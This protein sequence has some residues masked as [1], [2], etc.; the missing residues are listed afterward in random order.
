MGRTVTKGADGFFR[1][2][3]Q[4]EEE[5]FTDEHVAQRVAHNLDAAD[6]AETA[7]ACSD[8]DVVDGG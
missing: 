8:G 4:P 5:Y 7:D 3:G 6:A 2:S 1:V